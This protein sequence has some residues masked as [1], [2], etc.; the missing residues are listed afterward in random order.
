MGSVTQGTVDCSRHVGMECSAATHRVDP[1]HAILRARFLLLLRVPGAGRMRPETH[2]Q[3]LMHSSPS[4][5][6]R[7]SS[8]T[9]ALG[10]VH[11][12]TRADWGCNCQKS[13]GGLS[14]DPSRART[15][16][17]PAGAYRGLALVRL[18]SGFIL[19]LDSFILH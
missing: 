19:M 11:L 1:G 3:A 14:S 13:S 16:A 2:Q 17:R 9:G 5:P 7:R 10:H 8:A 12:V 4:G 6:S 15:G 18:I